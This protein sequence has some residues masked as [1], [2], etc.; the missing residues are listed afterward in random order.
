VPKVLDAARL[1]RAASATVVVGLLTAIGLAIR[2]VIAERALVGDEVSTYWVVTAHGMWG[3]LSTVH[4]DAEITPPLYFLASWATTLLGDAPQLV[5][6]PSLLAGTA[7]IPLIYL[8]GLRT[9]GRP[10]ALLA[11]G[12]TALSPFMIVLSAEARGYALM[13]FLV[14]GSTLAMLLALDERR[15]RWWIAYA[16]C[17]CAAVYTHYTSVFP[18]AAQ[19]LWLVWCHPDARRPAVLANLA[20]IV[21]FLPWTTGLVNDFT[22]PTT[23][24]L[25]GLAAH[26]V[27]AFLANLGQWSTGAYYGDV[28]LRDLPGVPALVLR[29]AAL[30]VAVVALAAVSIRRRSVSPRRPVDRRLVLLVALL[31]SAPVCEAILALLGTD[32]LLT[33]NLA[34]SWPALALCF[35]ALLTAAGPRLR[36][37]TVA[38]AAASFAI[39]AGLMLEEQYQRPDYQA[40]ANFVAERAE[41]GD[42]VL[43]LTSAFSAGPLS[44]L[45][46]TLHG[47]GR[48]RVLR[49]GSP[50]PRIPVPEAISAAV[51]TVHR[52][53]IF[54]VTTT[55]FRVDRSMA[56]RLEHP[57]TAP[58][59]LPAR[60]R[61]VE[62]RAFTGRF[63]ALVSTY[64]DPTAEP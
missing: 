60:F 8:L 14:M 62:T 19:L 4:G 32:L 45:D 27:H 25:A 53:R 49:A 48:A 2:L 13:T 36:L 42:V 9:V 22:S 15:S 20:A 34:S 24:I 63:G 38:L 52:G 7:S 21:A 6:T 35:A 17:L 3:V 47:R 18:L 56:R 40:A 30:V 54:V 55:Y 28:S 33:R 51:T 11:G 41:P 26:D 31:L 37:A 43:D 29:A 1:D 16:V 59:G 44:P 39:G 58:S 46:V 61:R 23:N 57:G 10:A 12:L 64:A 50:P 5:R